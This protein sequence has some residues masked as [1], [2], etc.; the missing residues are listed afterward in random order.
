MSLSNVLHMCND[1][2]AFLFVAFLLFE[3]WCV[4]DMIVYT[5]SLLSWLW[6]R[7]RHVRVGIFVSLSNNKWRGQSQ[8]E[9]T[10]NIQL[11]PVF[12][13]ICSY[14]TNRQELYIEGWLTL[15]LTPSIS[16]YLPSLTIK[17]CSV[18]LHRSLLQSNITTSTQCHSS[19]GWLAA[20]RQNHPLAPWPCLSRYT[21]THTPI[22]LIFI[23]LVIPGR[24]YASYIVADIWLKL[25]IGSIAAVLASI[26]LQQYTT[27]YDHT[28]WVLSYWGD[29][30][31]FLFLVDSYCTY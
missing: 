31:T 3:L 30:K 4:Y 15:A 12:L 11:L 26:V 19:S 8:S 29:T 18:C 24:R 22:H 23:H 20:H 28:R 21:H 9:P 1:G 5:H 6:C 2:S 10:L 7:L 13:Q 25:I 17:W 14:R 27:L 16:I